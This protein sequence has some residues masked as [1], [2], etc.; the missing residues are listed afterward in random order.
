MDNIHAPT[1]PSGPTSS[2]V[3]NGA[4]GRLSFAELERKKIAMEEELKALSSILDSVRL[5][6]YPAGILCLILSQHHV[7]MNTPLL[8]SDG[9]PRADIDVAQSMTLFLLAGGIKNPVLT[10]SSVRTTR[11]R[12]IHLKN[13][14]KELMNAIE[15]H[16]HE[17][18]ASIQDDD[19]DIPTAASSSSDPSRFGDSV[20]EQLGPVFARVNSVVPN[21]PADQAG[22]RAGD[23]I[24]NFGY[25]NAENHDGLK[26]VAECVQGNEGRDV[27]V[28]VSR[29]AGP[30]NRTDLRLK[31]T[32]RRNWGGRGLLGCHIVPL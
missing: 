30:A 32:P 23:E 20:P 7:D 17:H 1:V 8:T 4:T 11:S 19:D 12:I 27:F 24:R 5:C 31:L 14:Y 6:L 26:K 18:F 22:R 10:L 29:S 13:D 2:A 16:L 9:F 21:S 25:V 3:A 15:K 28:R